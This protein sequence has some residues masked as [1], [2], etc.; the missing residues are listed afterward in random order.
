[1]YILLLQN[2]FLTTV[3]FVHCKGNLFI[4]SFDRSV[5]SF[6]TFTSSSKTL[7]NAMVKAGPR[8]EK[9]PNI[10]R[11]SQTTFAQLLDSFPFTIIRSDLRDLEHQIFFGRSQRFWTARSFAPGKSLRFPCEKCLNVDSLPKIAYSGFQM[12]RFPFDSRSIFPIMCCN[13]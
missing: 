6:S 4:H 11:K 13:L 1:M 2:E 7:P 10:L 12:L 5:V 3:D 8:H 9:R